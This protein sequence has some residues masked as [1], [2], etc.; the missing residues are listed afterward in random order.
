MCLLI[1]PPP[2]K[3]FEKNILKSLLTLF[4]LGCY[5]V[6]MDRVGQNKTRTSGPRT[7]TKKSRVRGGA[8]NPKKTRVRG[9]SSGP[10]K[11]GSGPEKRGP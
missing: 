3:D 4:G 5:K 11:T 1:A 6:D 7:Q 2:C 9:P 8:P 10:E